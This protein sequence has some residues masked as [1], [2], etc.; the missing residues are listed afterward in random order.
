MV[1]FIQNQYYTEH[2]NWIRH[3]NLSETDS[4]NPFAKS[5]RFCICYGGADFYH[6]V[7]SDFMSQKYDM[8]YPTDLI[9]YHYAWWR[10]GKYLELRCEQLERSDEKWTAY[11]DGMDE[12]R[13]AKNE[14]IIVRPWFDDDNPRKYL[15]KINL[16]HPVHIMDHPNYLK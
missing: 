13:D 6:S 3:Q 14:L 16:Q 10:P 4:L 1:D 9:T 8:L 2:V 12:A 15:K 7:L 5:R 11:L